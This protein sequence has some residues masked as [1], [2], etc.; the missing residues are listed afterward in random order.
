MRQKINRILCATDFSEVSRDVVP[1][2]IR[3]ARELN[4]TLYICH[5]IDL[6]TI[7]V[8]GEAVFDPITQQHR[9]I[10]FAR[11]EI[12]SLVGDAPVEWQQLIPI[13]QTTE[14]IARQAGEK[15]V[16]LVITATH[17]RSGLKRLFLG[18]VT[19]R[20][21]RILSCPLLVLRSTG[22]SEQAIRQELPFKKILV[23]YDFSEDADA[24]FRTGLNMAQ[25][26]ESS[27]HLMHVVEPTAYRDY[28]RFPSNSGEPLR[29]DMYDSIKS[30]MQALVPDDALNWCSLETL[31]R[32]GKP[33][34]ELVRYAQTQA[35][36]L[37]ITG[38]RGHGMVEELLVGSTTDRVI[39]RAPCPVLSV[40]RPAEE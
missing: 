23:G 9:F 10:D 32:V 6:P 38:V 37:I 33:Y 15:A 13:G 25:E 28:A 30:R 21:M 27:L 4:A 2:G 5:V 39:R 8:Y 18:S 7:S 26:F 31:I 22:D 14:E 16:D 19:E 1:F 20:L 36:D 29:Q 3:M 24:A 12:E 11:Q 17:G 35:V 40:C 34:A